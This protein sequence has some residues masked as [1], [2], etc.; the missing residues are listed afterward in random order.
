MNALMIWGLWC[1]GNSF[2]WLF[3]LFVLQ[4]FRGWIGSPQKTCC[5]PNPP[6]PMNVTLF[7]NK[8]FVN[9]IKLKWG[10]VALGWTLIEG[11]L[12]TE[13]Q[14]QREDGHGKLE[15][16][17]K[18]EGMLPRAKECQGFPASTRRQE[19]T[20]KGSPLEPSEGARPSWH[21]DSHPLA[22]R[23]V[24][25]EVS[26]VFSRQVCGTSLQQALETMQGAVQGHRWE[27]WVLLRE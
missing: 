15:T 22:S 9:V 27:A 21:P 12:D 5:C 11:L 19:R 18:I 17:A 13:T 26:A 16:E 2:R 23:T 3:T 6:V 10:P 14:T 25:E 1:S 20:R 8:V 24:W 4:V 7:G